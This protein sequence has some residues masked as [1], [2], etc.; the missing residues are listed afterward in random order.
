MI[1][2]DKLLILLVI[3]F[4]TSCGTVPKLQ[5]TYSSAVDDNTMYFVSEKYQ[6][7]GDNFT[8]NYFTDMG[9][10]EK[11]GIGTFKQE[12]FRTQ[13]VFG[14]PPKREKTNATVKKSSPNP[15]TFEINTEV[16]VPDEKHMQSN[17]SILQ[18]TG[19]NQN[20]KVGIGEV[21]TIIL[22]NDISFPIQ[23]LVT[24]RKMEP[25]SLELE[26]PQNLELNVVLQPSIDHLITSVTKEKDIRK[27]GK[28]IYINGK[29]FKKIAKQ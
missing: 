25:F 17:I 14:K 21:K 10:H 8:Y 2:H 22:A 4:F 23:L 26:E 6:F 24:S 5:G 18:Y 20:Y 7:N 27:K 1:N 3:I 12:K 9:G 11:E 15:Y 29:K 28:Y 19:D 16:N 13:L